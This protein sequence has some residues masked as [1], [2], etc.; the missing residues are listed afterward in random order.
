VVPDERIAGMDSRAKRILL[1]RVAIFLFSLGL[2]WVLV[3]Y[4]RVFIPLAWGNLRLVN[5]TVN[6]TPTILSILFA[7]V[8]DKDLEVRMKKAWRVGIVACGLLWS[9]LLWHQQSLTDKQSDAQIQGAVDSA[10]EKSNKHTDTQ[11]NKVTETVNRVQE[12]VGG[13]QGQVSELGK[14]FGIEMEKSTS[15]LSSSIGKVGKPPDAK[16]V[17]L[18]NSI[19]HLATQAGEESKMELQIEVNHKG[20]LVATMYELSGIQEATDPDR[21]YATLL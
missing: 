17:V 19:V 5:F 1:R 8:I 2:C 16:T 15:E 11:F 3:H 20:P 6:F 18:K 12:K 7:F 10:V 4:G 14:S 9:I 21:N 13:V